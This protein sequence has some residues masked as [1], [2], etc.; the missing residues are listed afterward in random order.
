[1]KMKMK[2]IVIVQPLHPEDEV[3]VLLCILALES[4]ISLI[5]AT[6]VSLMKRRTMF[7]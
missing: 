1:M 3:K 5:M 2:M 7:V 6:I 4:W